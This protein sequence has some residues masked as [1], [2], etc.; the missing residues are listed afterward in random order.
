MNTILLSEASIVVRLFHY[1]LFSTMVPDLP[2]L[3]YIK[4]TGGNVGKPHKLK[5]IKKMNPTK[6]VNAFPMKAEL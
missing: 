2:Q 4:A 1:V 3:S 6:R 5:W